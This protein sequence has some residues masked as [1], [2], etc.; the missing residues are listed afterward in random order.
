MIMTGLKLYLGYVLG[1]LLVACI[2]AVVLVVGIYVLAK[3][4]K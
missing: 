4:S 3:L 2:T 1:T